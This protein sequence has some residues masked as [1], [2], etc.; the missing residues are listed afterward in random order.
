MT[1]LLVTAVGLTGVVASL[2]LLLRWQH[3]HRLASEHRSYRLQ[4]PLGLKPESVTTFLA[5][6]SGLLPPWYR[7]AVITNPI[8]L[9]I[10]STP[11]G[12]AHYL[13]VPSRL[14]AIVAAHLRAALPSVR[15]T[16]D[17]ESILRRPSRATELTISAPAPPL[18]SDHLAAANAA[19]LSS[20]QPLKDGE[21]AVVQWV[22]APAGLP[23]PPRRQRPEERRPRHW[24]WDPFAPQASEET[25]E[26]LRDQRAKQSEPLFRAVGA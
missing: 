23:R 9:E 25:A 7:R 20:L 24:L 14:V 11:G 21:S 17:A 13:V 10:H 2:V 26:D 5:G 16:L 8:V 22:V 4:F 19:T 18:R 15:L 12:I 6:L 3:L 1:E